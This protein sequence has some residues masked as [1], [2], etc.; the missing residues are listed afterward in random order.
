MTLVQAQI[1]VQKTSL[2]QLKKKP[3][4]C[5]EVGASSMKRN[6]NIAKAG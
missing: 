5:A 1:Y 3:C 4:E 2:Q 6:I